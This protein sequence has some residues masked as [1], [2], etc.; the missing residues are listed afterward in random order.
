[1]SNYDHVGEILFL[2]APTLRPVRLVNACDLCGSHIER[3]RLMLCL[4]CGRYACGFD[5][6][7]P[8]CLECDLRR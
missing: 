5:T 1:M 8:R 4:E 7:W 3:D 2:H 6:C